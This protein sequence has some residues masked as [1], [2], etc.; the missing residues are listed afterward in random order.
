MK[1]DVDPDDRFEWDLTAL[2]LIV[3]V[4]IL[5]LLMVLA[6]GPFGHVT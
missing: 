2:T 6:L 1:P 3:F 5:G 4:V